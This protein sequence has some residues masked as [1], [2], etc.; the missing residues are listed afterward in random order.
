MYGSTEQRS[1]DRTLVTSVADIQHFD[2]QLMAGNAWI[3]EE[4][5]LAQ[6]AADVGSANADLVDANQRLAGARFFRGGN[7]DAL[8]ISRGAQETAL[9]WVILSG[10]GFQLSS[11]LVR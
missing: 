3:A 2:A 1:P 9:S 5:H 10:A 4:R 6:V 7:I 11:Y 8:P